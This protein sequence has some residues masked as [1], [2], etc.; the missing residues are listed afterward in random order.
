MYKSEKR[1][2]FSCLFEITQD[3]VIAGYFADQDGA[4]L[5]MSNIRGIAIFET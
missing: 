1:C 4:Y 2:T 5:R 3:R